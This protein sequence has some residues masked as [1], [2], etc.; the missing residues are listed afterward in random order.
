MF[1]KGYFATWASSMSMPRPGRSLRPHVAVADFRAAGEDLAGFRAEVRLFLDAEVV[2]GQVERHIGGVSDR[3]NVAGPCQAVRT[4][5]NRRA[6][7]ASGP[8][9]RPPILG[10]V[11]ADKVDQAVFDQR[12]VLL[13]VVEEFAHGELA[14]PSGG[15]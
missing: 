14:L 8:G 12:H 6:P 7:P 1:G 9:S 3:G 5:K 4:P 2:A 10:D 15:A 13:R 11:D